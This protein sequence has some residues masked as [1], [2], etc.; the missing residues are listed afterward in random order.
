MSQ[1]VVKKS[2]TRKKTPADFYFWAESPN[3]A[4]FGTTGAVFSITP[5]AYFD[6]FNCLSDKSN[7]CTCLPIGFFELM[8]SCYEFVDGSA[9]GRELLLSLGMVELDMLSLMKAKRTT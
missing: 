7:V 8:E 5:K 6:K 2:A 4:M 9:K 3:A 1:P